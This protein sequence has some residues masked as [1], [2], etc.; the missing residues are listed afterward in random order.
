MI[1]D[2]LIKTWAW[3]IPVAVLLEVVIAAYLHAHDLERG[4][5]K[6]GQYFGTAGNIMFLTF[7][8][9]V[10]AVMWPWA[11]LGAIIGATLKS[12]WMTLVKKMRHFIRYVKRVEVEEK[13]AGK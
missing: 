1:G 8:G 13:M 5:D 9:F 2:I 7:V 6:E 3:G 10:I 4:M 12:C 11:L